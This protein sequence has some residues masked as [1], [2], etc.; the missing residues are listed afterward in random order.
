[1]SHETKPP[2]SPAPTQP[3]PAKPPAPPKHVDLGPFGNDEEVKKLMKYG[4]DVHNS[5]LPKK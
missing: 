2:A 1:M 3:A 5:R 4:L